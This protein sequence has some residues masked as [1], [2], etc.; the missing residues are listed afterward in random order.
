M[1]TYNSFLV[2]KNAIWV[3]KRR[4]ESYSRY[5]YFFYLQLKQKKMNLK[6]KMSNVSSNPFYGKIEL[7]NLLNTGKSIQSQEMMDSALNK[8]WKECKDSKELREAFYIIC[9]S[10]G[11]I[12]NRQHNIFGK[13]KKDDGGNAS[14]KQMM[15]ILSWIRKNNSIQYY[16]FM[17]SRLINEFVSWA[18]ILSA[19]VRTKKGTKKIEKTETKTF[20]ALSEQDLDK[21]AEY[22]SKTIKDGSYLD[23][24]LLSK[25]L[26]LPRTSKRIKVNREGKKVGKRDLQE[27]TKKLMKLKESLYLKLSAILNWEVVYHKHN[28]EFKGLKEFKQSLNTSFESVLFSTKEI[29]KYDKEQFFKLLEITPSNARYRI[30]RRLLD[31]DGNS[32]QKWTSSTG[33]DLAIWFK[34]WE[35]FKEEKQAE[36]RVLTEK[37]RQGVATEKDKKQL[38][39]VKKQ[40]K[41]T[42]GATTLFDQINSSMMGNFDDVLMQSILDK[43]NFEVPVLVINDC[44]GSMSGL[45]T[46]IARLLTVTAMLKNPSKDL[47]NM[48]VRFGSNAEF[49]TD[50]S[51]GT[52]QVNRFM[53]EKSVKVSKLIDRTMPFSWNYN[54]IKNFVNSNMGGTDFSSVAKVFYEWINND[55][56]FRQQ[57]IE[58][59]QQ[60]PVIL[61]VSDGDMNSDS[62]AADSMMRFMSVMHQI[63]WNGVVVVWDVKNV[64]YSLSEIGDKFANVPNCVHYYGY[65]LGIIN[66]IFTNIHDLDV[67][68]VY[69]E[70]KSLHASNRYELIKQ[71]TL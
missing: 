46:N 57:R 40:A 12:T 51:K 50:F 32:K 28:V 35:K 13:T 34:N 54:N 43:I 45:S 22:L 30:Q 23:K 16:K 17:F 21:L 4:F 39:Q 10:I 6:V 29:C 27:T 66:Q 20:N 24:L 31:K 64:S 36:Q 14:R 58:Q 53:L 19:Q 44:S 48:L 15:W 68:D 55:I 71:N 60:Y 3:P 63:G 33:E 26:V 38:E 67:I 5:N 1:N 52:Q 2:N 65:N 11:D 56:N 25:W 8:A 70:I 41:V 7:K 37:V 69:Q 47:D 49:V 18:A 42:T 61:V 59:L 9:F 62:T